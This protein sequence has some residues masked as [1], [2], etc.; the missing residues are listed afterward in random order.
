MSA[1]TEHRTFCFLAQ[2]SHCEQLLLPCGLQSTVFATCLFVGVLTRTGVPRPSAPENWKVVVCAPNGDNVG[3]GSALCGCSRASGQELMLM[4]QPCLV[5][6][7][8]F[9]R[10]TQFRTLHLDQLVKMWTQRHEEQ[11][12]GFP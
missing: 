9:N 2:L 7:V 8:S 10:N 6:T 11:S 5:S 3:A 12:P 4:V 1:E